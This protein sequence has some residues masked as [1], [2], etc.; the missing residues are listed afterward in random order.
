MLNKTTLNPFLESFQ[1]CFDIRRLKIR[2]KMLRYLLTCTWW[3][4][5]SCFNRASIHIGLQLL[6]LFLNARGALNISHTDLQNDQIEKYGEFF[7]FQLLVDLLID[8]L[9]VHLVDQTVDKPAKKAKTVPAPDEPS[10]TGF[11]RNHFLSSSLD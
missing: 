8:I 1:L 5:I 7:N 2:F 3:F 9:F 4:R 6:F 11:K 10:P